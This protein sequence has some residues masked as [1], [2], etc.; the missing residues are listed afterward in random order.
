MALRLTAYQ[1]QGPARESANKHPIRAQGLYAIAANVHALSTAEGAEG[2][3]DAPN[4][5]AQ[6]A[7]EDAEEEDDDAGGVME[8]CSPPVLSGHASSRPQY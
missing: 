2:E 5:R 4:D 6:N 7:R 1:K 8:V 3:R